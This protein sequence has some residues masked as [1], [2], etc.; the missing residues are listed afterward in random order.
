MDAPMAEEFWKK[1]K[2]GAE[3]NRLRVQIALTKEELAANIRMMQQQ[4]ASGERP[5]FAKRPEANSTSPLSAAPRVSLPAVPHPLN[6]Q[7]AFV[8]TQPVAPPKP[9]VIKIY[10]L[11]DGVREVKL[12]HE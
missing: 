8:A 4:Q 5:Y 1:V 10:G 12:D 2:V 11:D 9:R 3:G 7:P 6:S